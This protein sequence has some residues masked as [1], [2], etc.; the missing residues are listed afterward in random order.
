MKAANVSEKDDWRE[1]KMLNWTDLDTAWKGKNML[2][3]NIH[4]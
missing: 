3:H 4:S 2:R 1:Y